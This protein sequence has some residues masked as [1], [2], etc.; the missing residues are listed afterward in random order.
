MNC[1][2]GPSQASVAGSRR[3]GWPAVLLLA[4]GV[5]A[6][7]QTPNLPDFGTPAD[8]VLN[9]SQE[10]QL[11]RGVMAQLRSA[12]AIMDDPIVT[13]YIQT[14]GARLAG[15]ANDG[16]HRFEFFVVD[17]NAINAFALPGGF[18]GMNTGLILASERESEVAGV[19]AHEVAHVTQRHIARSIYS[20]QRNSILSMAA[21]IAAVL[22]GAAADANSQA[23]QGLITASQAAAIQAQINYTRANEH[24]ADRIGI[25][26]LASAGFDPTAMATFFEKLSRRYA[27]SSDRVPSFLQTHPVTSERV[28]EARERARLLPAVDVTDSVSYEVVKARL[29]VLSAPSEEAA[30]EIFSKRM[31]AGGDSVADRYGYALI[32]H[33]HSRHDLAQRMFSDLV[34]EFPGVIAFRIGE[35]EALIESYQTGLALA[36]FEEA[37]ELSPRNVPLTLSYANALIPAGY[38]AK[39]HDLLLDLLNN[40]TPTPEQFRLIARAANAE[41]DIGNA[42]HYMSHYYLSIGNLALAFNQIRMALESPGVNPVDRERFLTEFQDLEAHVSEQVRAR[43]SGRRD[44]P[45]VPFR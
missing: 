42:H 38:P 44:G 33:R 41:G 29:E 12:G 45:P 20:N 14:L 11:G 26:T 17:D 24:E 32:L 23:M 35:A 31:D 15:H 36:R 22:L 8:S 34:E 7:A 37:I 19:L 2:S 40:S 10:A 1:S 13:E 27:F 43:A 25:G 6:A 21:M 3:F 4:A 39:A 30:L 16:D 5:N 18:I 28:G 9:R